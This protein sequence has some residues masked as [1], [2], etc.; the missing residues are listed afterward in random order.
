MS[1]SKLVDL[2][3]ERPASPVAKPIAKRRRVDAAAAAPAPQPEHLAAVTTGA[4]LVKTGRQLEVVPGYNT[5]PFTSSMIRDNALVIFRGSDHYSYCLAGN[6]AECD[7]DYD[8]IEPLGSYRS[9]AELIRAV[10]RGMP[11]IVCMSRTAW[12]ATE[13]ARNSDNVRRMVGHIYV[14]DLV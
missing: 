9:A 4:V 6:L 1:S 5:A 11:P 7:V 10:Y 12:E 13:L 2:T 3:D 14:F 8:W